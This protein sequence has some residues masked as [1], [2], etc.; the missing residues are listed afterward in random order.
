M[1]D[2]PERLLTGSRPSMASIQS[3]RSSS[4]NA[5]MVITPGLRRKEDTAVKPAPRVDGP[6]KASLR[7]TPTQREAAGVSATQGEGHPSAFQS[8]LPASDS[9]AITPIRSQ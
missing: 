3:L 6:R 2:V 8:H 7:E 9:K 4:D 5:C 1:L